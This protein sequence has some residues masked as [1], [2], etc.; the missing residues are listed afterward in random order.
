MA[1]VLGAVRGIDLVVDVVVCLHDIHKG[2]L[3][4][5]AAGPDA[6][7]VAYLRAAVPRGSAPAPGSDVE[8][9]AHT[10]DPDRHG[11]SQR[12]I[13]PERRDPQFDCCSDIVELIARPR[14]HWCVSFVMP[15]A[16]SAFPVARAALAIF[17]PIPRPASKINQTLLMIGFL[18]LNS[19]TM[20]TKAE[21]HVLCLEIL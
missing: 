21:R 11:V 4:L 6:T 1:A 17:F 15:V 13:A 8:V 3:F 12:A 2:D 20:P 5:D 10:D 18:V 14:N 7:L 16:M 9:I 19:S